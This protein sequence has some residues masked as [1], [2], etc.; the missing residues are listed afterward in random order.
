[1]RTNFFAKIS[2]IVFALVFTEQTGI[3]R[4]NDT[5]GKGLM[6]PD[7]SANVEKTEIPLAYGK[8]R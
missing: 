8:S 3:Y 1:M 7:N 5:E 2:N 4:A 6:S